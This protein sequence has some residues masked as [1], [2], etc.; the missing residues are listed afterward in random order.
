MRRTIGTCLVLLA[1]A[2]CGARRGYVEKGNVLF[3]QGKYQDAAIN[4]RKAIQKDPNNG[5]A[6][7]RLGL[8]SIQQDQGKDAY[9]ALFRAY[10]LLPNN[11]EVRDKFAGFCLEYYL[12]DPN[13]PQ[14]LYQQIQQAASELLSQNPN[15]F[16]G[17][18]LKAYLAHADRKP[19]LAISYFRRALQA[20]PWNAPVTTALV[21]IL[22]ENGASQEGEKMGRELI[23]RAK[24]YGPA[25]DL[26]YAFYYNVNRVADAENILKIKVA[27]NPKQISSVLQLAAHYERVQKPAEAKAALQKLLDDPKDFPDAK[28]RAGDF[29]LSEKNY[30]EALGYYEAAA[31]DNPKNAVGLQKRELGTMLAASKYDDASRTVDQIL[32]T[33]PN[34]QLALRIRADL[35]IASKKP[36]NAERAAQILQGLLKPDDPDPGLRVQLG[37]A[38]R[39]QGNL[40]GA[41]AQFTEALRLRKD[42]AAA[43]YELGELNLL[44]QRP[45]EALQEATAAVTLMPTDRRVRLLQARSLMS[46]GDSIKARSLLNQLIKES[47]KDNEARLQLGLLFLQQADYHAAIDILEELRGDGDPTVFSSLAAAYVG[48]HQFDKAIVILSEGLKRSPGSAIIRE[49]LAETTALEGNYGLAIVQFQQLIAQDPKSARLRFRLA[50][51]YQTKGD[52]QNA[53]LSYQKAHD[54]APEEATPALVL[55]DALAQAGRTDEAKTL[56]RQIVKSH[57]DNPPALNNAAFFLSDHGDLDEAQRLAEKALEKIPGQ[58]G[59]SDTLGYVYLKKGQRDDAI[60]TFSELVRRYPALALFHYHLGL[61]LYEKGD[62]VAAKKELQKALVTHP[63]SGIEPRIR[64]LLG[65]LS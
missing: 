35:L 49:Q 40:A 58:P 37:R 11:F 17:L 8:V 44:Q 18:R 20:Q 19:D 50:E 4:Y 2:A 61:A 54:L 28:L 46:T 41:R 64:K 7:Y 12:R 43:Q 33:D 5:E 10:Q 45:N 13:R 65:S 1:I 34:D 22:L 59:F 21:Q 9:N 30:Q 27:N 36:D 52:Q 63:G 24:T 25:Y 14:R 62:R 48:L 42:F 32:K 16:E 60:R 47:P 23:E 53:L 55:A 15:S 3:Q 56:Y 31:R 57:P 26:L 39:L 29:Y 38:Y 6:Y 51:V